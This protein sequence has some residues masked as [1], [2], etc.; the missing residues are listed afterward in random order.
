MISFVQKEPFDINSSC[1]TK[2]QLNLF[3]KRTKTSHIN[4]QIISWGVS[5]VLIAKQ[6]QSNESS[7]WDT[8]LLKVNL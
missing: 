4:I 7:A 6:K 8:H 2:Y 5:C 3:I 1:L